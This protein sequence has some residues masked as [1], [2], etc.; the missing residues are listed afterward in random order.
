MPT[1]NSIA[2][3]A[4]LAAAHNRGTEA[5][6]NR[7]GMRLGAARF[8]AGE[9]LEQELQLLRRLTQQGFKCNATELGEAVTSQ[10]DADGA[11]SDYQ[12]LLQR[13]A[14]E[15]L[16]AS[17]AIKLTLMG[18]D[19]EA[20]L[21]LENMSRLLRIASELGLFMRLDM[22]NS[23]HVEGTLTTYRQLRQAGFDNIGCVLQSCLRRSAQDLEELL[24]LGLNLRLV[25]GAYLEPASIAY[26][27]KTDVDAN[28]VR[29][30]DR[31][32]C[33]GKYTAVAT[34]DPRMIEHTVNFT[35]AHGI[36]PDRFEFQML[37]G[38]RPQL[39]RQLL[40]R[41]YTVLVATSYGSHWYPFF[42]RRLAERPANLL[43]LAR[44]LMHT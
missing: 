1:L 9:T 34:H 24:P 23:A 20:Q 2:R 22:E 12:E 37:Y 42:M 39:Q 27:R 29:L 25:K 3:T 14:A 43:F 6:V 30:L 8:V 28:Y 38:V 36:G 16:N 10:E 18:Q 15:R 44:S 21:A 19:I 31:A 5:L 26:T 41:G 4:I 17:V 40:Q 13:I 11:V 32:L 33:A 7:F 35:A